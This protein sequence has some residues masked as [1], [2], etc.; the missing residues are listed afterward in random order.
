M[1]SHF[2]PNS[3]GLYFH[4]LE[5]FSQP[6]LSSSQLA[7]CCHCNHFLNEDSSSL[8]W[9]VLFTLIPWNGFSQPI[10][11]SPQFTLCCLSSDI[12]NENSS[13]LHWSLLFTLIPWNGFSQP[14]LISPQSALGCHDSLFNILV[15]ATFSKR[16]HRHSIGL[17]SLP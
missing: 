9:S 17:Y 2:L 13:S 4:T 14:I 15:S 11:N 10:L 16:I 5:S 6:T 1:H 7:F 12:L 3:I 8:H